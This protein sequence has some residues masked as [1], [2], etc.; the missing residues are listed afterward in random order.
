MKLENYK[1]THLECIENKSSMSAVSQ[2]NE[3][4]EMDVRAKEE[5]PELLFG[6]VNITALSSLANGFKTG[7]CWR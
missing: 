4:F 1:S 6:K 7:S 3:G 2:E 5:R